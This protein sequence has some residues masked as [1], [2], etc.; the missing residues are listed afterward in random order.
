[1]DSSGDE[2]NT[3]QS[4]MGDKFHKGRCSTEVISFPDP[5]ENRGMANCKLK[6]EQA[7]DCK[8]GEDFQGSDDSGD[9]EDEEDDE[10]DGDD[11]DDECN[12]S[13]RGEE[14]VG[15]NLAFDTKQHGGT[16]NLEASLLEV[17][18]A[19]KK[20]Q[21]YLKVRD[22]VTKGKVTF[23]MIVDRN[24]PE[25]ILKRNDLDD[26][27]DCLLQQTRIHLDNEGLIELDNFECLGAN[28][29]SLYL[30]NNALRQLT[31]LELLVS[32]KSLVVS[33]NVI[34][35]WPDLRYCFFSA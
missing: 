27:A 24:V 19:E 10:D 8:D 34:E 26:I 2:N 18:E 28:V 14:N 15:M 23:K 35:Q 32:L 11:D 5:N 7:K 33:Y 13:D 12:E 21:Q 16:F 29:T 20:W 25:Q 31:N 1:M 30:Q 17:D 22:S 4:N 9:E 6:V 3:A